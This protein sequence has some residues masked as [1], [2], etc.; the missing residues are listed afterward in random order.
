[1]QI[2]ILSTETL[3]LILMNKDITQ[4]LSM[5]MTSINKHYIDITVKF[6]RSKRHVLMTRQ[7]LSLTIEGPVS[8]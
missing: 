3:L 2:L 1:M 4:T 6:N 8:T 7:I 5:S